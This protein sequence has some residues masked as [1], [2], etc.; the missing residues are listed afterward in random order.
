MNDTFLVQGGAKTSAKKGL[1]HIT[2]IGHESLKDNNN[3]SL[4]DQTYTASVKTLR[5]HQSWPAYLDVPSRVYITQTA[6]FDER[7]REKSPT[8]FKLKRNNKKN[9]FNLLKL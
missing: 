3:F 5:R 6:K 2:Y 9:N 8:S 7:V 1:L 4:T